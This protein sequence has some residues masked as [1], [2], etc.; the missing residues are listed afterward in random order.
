MMAMTLQLLL[1]VD[2]PTFH[3]MLANAVI[4]RSNARKY[5][6]R[7]IIDVLAR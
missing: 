7:R 3:Q 6:G 4:E 5:I 2:S 1:I